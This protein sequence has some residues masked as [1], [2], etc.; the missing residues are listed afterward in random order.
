MKSRPDRVF[1]ARE[2]GPKADVNDGVQDMMM[3]DASSLVISTEDDIGELAPRWVVEYAGEA[4]IV[5]NVQR[6]RVA[7]RSEFSAEPQFVSY[8]Q[9]RK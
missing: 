9:L 8:I 3:F 4:W 6:R 2:E 5:E 7:K 1:Y